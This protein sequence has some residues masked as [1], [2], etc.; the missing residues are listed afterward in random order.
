MNFFAA[1][2]IDFCWKFIFTASQ[3]SKILAKKDYEAEKIFPLF[4]PTIISRRIVN[5]RRWQKIAKLQLLQTQVDDTDNLKKPNYHLNSDLQ[6][7]VFL[8]F[9]KLPRKHLATAVWND[10][11][12][13]SSMQHWSFRSSTSVLND[14]SMQSSMLECS[15]KCSTAVFNPALYSWNETSHT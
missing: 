12:M 13:Q 9:W 8:S 4:L 1:N 7:Y 2:L 10:A 5:S 11:S 3:K 6:I 14:A 15:L